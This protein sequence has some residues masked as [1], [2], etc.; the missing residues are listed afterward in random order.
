[1]LQKW[2]IFAYYCEFLNQLKLAFRLI[3]SKFLLVSS[4]NYLDKFD[5]NFLSF[6]ISEEFRAI[7]I[8]V[9]IKF[10]L[11]VLWILIYA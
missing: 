9:L 1:M 3:I 11:F 8:F 7:Q 5:L 4:I 2:F 6:G 10:W